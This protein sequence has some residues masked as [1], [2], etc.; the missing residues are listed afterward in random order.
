M[1]GQDQ[2]HES[3]RESEDDPRRRRPGR[4][5]ALEELARMAREDRRDQDRNDRPR[6]R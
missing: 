2:P 6:Q 4:L 1:S 3:P 5:E